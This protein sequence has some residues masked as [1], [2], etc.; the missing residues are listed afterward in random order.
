MTTSVFQET[1]TTYFNRARKVNQTSNPFLVRI[2]QTAEP[3]GD[4]SLA[5]QPAVIDLG[6]T[7]QKPGI[8]GQNFV[9]IVPYGTGAAGN[10]FSLRVIGWGSI[11]T[12]TQS[13]VQILWVPVSLAEFV[14]TLGTPVGAAG[15]IIDN[16]NFFAQTITAVYGYEGVLDAIVSPNNNTIAHC[17]VDLRGFQK[18]EF[19]FS[20]GGSAADCNALY[21]LL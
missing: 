6:N 17:L 1:L 9:R 14:V 7:L 20:T 11:G 15:A 18:I 4:P 12:H 5:A 10:T 8:A 2:P 19:S 16:T 21:A 13:P 3:V